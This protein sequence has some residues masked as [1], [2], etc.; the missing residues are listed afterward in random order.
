MALAEYRE[1]LQHPLRQATLS[2]L[3]REGEV[4]LAMKKRG[5]GEGKWN[6][7]GGKPEENEQIDQ[8]AIREIREEIK[9]NP[10][11]IKRVG[12]LN[13]F[14]PHKTEWEQQV[15]V[16]IVDEWEGEP[17]ESE[18][19][20]PKWLVYKDIPFDNMWPDDIHWV[21]LVL[22]GKNVNAEFIFDQD[23]NVT[24]FVVIESP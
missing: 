24:E 11:S 3:I 8:T 2:F 4:L 16:Y 15:C 9:V 1:K 5:F 23:M 19:M 7:V 10:I 6:G 12:T 17:T 13:F 14:V 21:P 22:E 20:L 18:E